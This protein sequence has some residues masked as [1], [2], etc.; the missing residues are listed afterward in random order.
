MADEVDRAQLEI[1]SELA[2][3]KLAA[4]AGLRLMPLGH[5]YNCD[6][7]VERSG[8]LF[9]D[10]ECARDFEKRQRAIAWQAH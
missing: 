4:Q 10:Q 9:C 7:H 3:A 5:C 8:Q 1:E 6:E 2:Y